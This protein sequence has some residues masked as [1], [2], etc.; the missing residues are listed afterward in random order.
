MNGSDT[1]GYL[2]PTTPPEIEDLALDEFLQS[3]VVGITGLA[4]SLVRPRWQPVQL[5]QPPQAATWAAIGV[6]DERDQ[7]ASVIH[8]DLGNGYD[9][10]THHV[11]IEVMVSFYGPS[12]RGLANLFRDGLNIAQNREQLQLNDMGLVDVDRA[13][14][15]P[16]I[17]NE[18][19]RQR[20]DVTF[21]LRMA[22]ISRYAVLN[23]L[24]AQGEIVP[25][26]GA[27]EPWDTA[28]HAGP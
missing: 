12:S 3:L 17:V 20:V 7:G 22:R 9:E 27:A 28:N 16:E 15:A 10:E 18:V 25:E 26:S 4:G 19:W 23:L 13:V 5:P 1:V 2:T 11:L 14:N 6:I 21:R 24:S 8:F